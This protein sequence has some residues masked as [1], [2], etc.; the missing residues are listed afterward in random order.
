MDFEEGDMVVEGLVVLAAVVLAVVV[1][2]AVG[3]KRS[4]ICN[5]NFENIPGNFRLR[6]NHANIINNNYS[7]SPFNKK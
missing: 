1:Q 6:L 5:I 7:H 2:V 3:R 4:F